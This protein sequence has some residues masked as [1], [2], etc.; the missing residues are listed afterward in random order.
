MDVK[1][2]LCGNQPLKVLYN[3]WFTGVS[4][5]LQDVALV[6]FTAIGAPDIVAF[7]LAQLAC[8]QLT[9]IHIPLLLHHICSFICSTDGKGLLGVLAV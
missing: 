7:V 1:V 5:L 8:I 2:R 3:T 6:A 4:V 9:L